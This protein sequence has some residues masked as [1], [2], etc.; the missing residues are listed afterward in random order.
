MSLKWLAL[1]LALECFACADEVSLIRVGENW[2]YFT[3]L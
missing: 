1:L 2:R 3:D